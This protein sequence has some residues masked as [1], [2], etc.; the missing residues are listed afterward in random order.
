MSGVKYI[1]IMI[2]TLATVQSHPA[3]RISRNLI[4]NIQKSVNNK[5]LIIAYNK[6][7][8]IDVYNCIIDKNNNTCKSLVNY[9]NFMTIK[10]DC[11][12]KYNEG[13]GY[14]VFIIIVVWLFL[15]F[16]ISDSREY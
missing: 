10:E 12:N 1:I 6:T 4:K 11:I 8:N 2:I 16:L 9:D 3:Y 5:C 15:L 13:N 14:G 7:D